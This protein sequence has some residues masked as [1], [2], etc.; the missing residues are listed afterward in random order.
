MDGPKL[1]LRLEGVLGQLCRALGD[2]AVPCGP[3]PEDITE[4]LPETVAQV[5]HYLMRHVAGTPRV[6]TVFD[7]GQ[8][9]VWIAKDMIALRINRRVKLGGS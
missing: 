4:T 2:A 5:C 3:V 9:R 7:Q 1:A 6:V 8:F